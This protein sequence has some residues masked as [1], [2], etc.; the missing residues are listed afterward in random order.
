MGISSWFS[1]LGGKRE[2]PTDKKYSRNIRE[3]DSTGTV[4]ANTA[5]LEGVYL[6]TEPSFQ[7]A[8]PYANVPINVPVALVGIP[9]PTA[10]DDKTKER[11]KLLI[12]AKR[13][14]FP[15]I[16]RDKLLYGTAWRWPKYSV[17]MNDAIMESIPDDTVEALEI[18]IESGEIVTIF[19][20]DVYTISVGRDRTERRERFRK[21]TK[22]RIEVRWNGP[23][24]ALSD[25][26]GRNPFG[27]LPRPFGHDCLNGEWRGHCVYGRI[28][29]VMKTYHEVKLQQLRILAD[30][31]PKL[32][33]NVA[34][35]KAWMAI[36]GYNS[37]DD[38]DRDVF[39]A[40]FFLNKN[41]DEKTEM[42][43]LAE[44]ATAGHDKACEKLE[45]AMI[46]GSNIPELFWGGLATGNAASTDIQKDQVVQY[47]QSLQAEE[48]AQYEGLFND[49]LEILSFVEMTQY[50][51]VKM[52]W[53]KIDMMSEETK[54]K[55][56][57]SVSGAIA[58]IVNSA[59]GSIDDV[60]WFWKKFY[61][62][63]PET[64]VAKFTTGIHDMAKHKAF[65]MTDAISQGESE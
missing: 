18:D 42:L 60:Y 8:S 56:L 63:M 15:I 30:F 3:R 54:A 5:M 1:S 49:L 48:T 13:E 16:E 55:V 59:G 33:H 20:H 47:I 41:G 39:E 23:R 29:R 58:A 44:N 57:Q 40:T 11:L 51:K 28:L 21:I 10:D 62:D 53:D 43:Y 31:N 12:N 17:K 38:I 26:S 46:V 61:P 32:I 50:S 14:E 7:Y 9:T 65:A 27:H 64:D 19:T 36:N 22:D 2:T 52:G 35:V 37:I 24:G 4:V 45:R 34:D 6:G 25:S